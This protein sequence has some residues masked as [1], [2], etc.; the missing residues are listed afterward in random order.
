MPDHLLPGY[1][2]PFV[3]QLGQLVKIPDPSCWL[4]DHTQFALF[5]AG[6]PP[7]RQEQLRQRMLHTKGGPVASCIG[8]TSAEALV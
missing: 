5:A 7:R 8:L 2:G 3:Q 6:L 1:L 4:H